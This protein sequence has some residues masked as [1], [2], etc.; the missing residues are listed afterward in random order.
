MEQSPAVVNS[1]P[2]REQAPADIAKP[3]AE[4][5]EVFATSDHDTA[6]GDGNNLLGDDV[7]SRVNHARA[8]SER[9]LAVARR[10]SS[11]AQYAASRALAA[12][13]PSLVALAH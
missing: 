2:V 7:A 11:L 6:V 12:C 9:N 4:M 10:K 13:G 3:P 8:L 1:S 5:P